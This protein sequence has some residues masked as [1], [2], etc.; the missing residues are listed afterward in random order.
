MHSGGNQLCNFIIIL[1]F[2]VKLNILNYRLQSNI[3]PPL[4]IGIN[5]MWSFNKSTDL[6]TGLIT[7]KMYLWR[8]PYHGPNKQVVFSCQV[9]VGGVCCHCITISPG[10]SLRPPVIKSSDYHHIRWFHIWANVV[11]EFC[12]YRIAPAIV[13]QKFCSM[14][15]RQRKCC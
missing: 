13:E 11:M 12:K 7:L 14:F 9:V 8:P 1:R 15:R 6:Y 4:P 2:D 5:K 3:G 10:A